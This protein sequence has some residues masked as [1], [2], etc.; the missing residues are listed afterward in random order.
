[1]RIFRCSSPATGNRPADGPP[2]FTRRTLRGYSLGLAQLRGA[3]FDCGRSRSGPMNDFQM[4]EGIF[5]KGCAAFNPVSVVEVKDFPDLAHL[6]L[7][8]VTANHA[9][10]AARLGGLR[11]SVLKA[12]DIFDGVFDGVL[13]V[14]GKRPVG[15]AEGAAD[16]VQHLV[17]L[18]RLVIGP[19]PKMG[20]PLGEFDHAVELIA[21][22][23]EQLL[24]VRGL[25]DRLLRDLDAGIGAAAIGAQEFVVI[26]GHED[27]ARAFIHLAQDL[28]HHVAVRVGPV[29][30][31]LELPA[32]DDVADQIERLAGIL[33]EEVAQEFRLATAGA[34]MDVRYEYRPME[35]RWTR[36]W[37]CCAPA[38]GRESGPRRRD[39]PGYSGHMPLLLA[40]GYANRAPF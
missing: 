21:V 36:R 40:T 30:A 24:A 37:R 17:Y 9:I 15:Q 8:D 23:D 5:D 18:Q 25:V 32:V 35:S 6:R 31:A 1:M 16:T 29:P 13:Q 19:G 10:E 27:H 4:S 2:V 38:K 34:E 22:D 12:A 20:E 39:Q 7:M 3:G 14:V 26:A 33:G 11:N 28:L